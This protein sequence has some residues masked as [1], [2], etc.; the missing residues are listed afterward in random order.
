GEDPAIDALRALDQPDDRRVFADLQLPE[1]R[2][3][4]ADARIAGDAAEPMIAL[5]PADEPGERL[6]I[7][8]RV[9]VGADEN[10]AAGEMRADIHRRGLA[11]TLR[12]MDDAQPRNPRGEVI[13]D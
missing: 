12:E 5:Q 3:A 4:V 11:L 8:Q 6:A 10:L 1:Q 7:E 9:A 13:E 2:G